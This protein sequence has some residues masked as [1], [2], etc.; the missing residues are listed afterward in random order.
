MDQYYSPF[1]DNLE[2]I[3]NNPEIKQLFFQANK[4]WFIDNLPEIIR[5]NESNNEIDQYLK[6][7]YD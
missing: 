6:Q 4:V 1:D 5:D 2:L 3:L 7:I